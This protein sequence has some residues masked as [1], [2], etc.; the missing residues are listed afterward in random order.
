MGDMEHAA[1]LLGERAS[2]PGYGDQQRTR[3][4]CGI[5]LERHVS[6]L[7]LFAADD[8]SRC[9]AALSIEPDVFHEHHR[10]VR[11]PHVS[12][13]SASDRMHGKDFSDPLRFRGLRPGGRMTPWGLLL[14]SDMAK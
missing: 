11:C 4:H 8:F 2:R 6:C 14:L 12:E 13:T 10:L 1:R 7:P 3:R 5:K 9:R